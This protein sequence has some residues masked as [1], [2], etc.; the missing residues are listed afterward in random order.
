MKNLH[1]KLSLNLVSLLPIQPEHKEALRKA[2]QF[3]EV[4]THTSI[5]NKY[6]SELFDTWFALAFNQTKSG[7]HMTYLVEYQGQLVGSTRY[8]AIRPEQKEIAIGFTWYTPAVWGTVVNPSC[9]LLLFENAFSHGYE[10]VFFH[11]DIKNVHSQ[12]AIKKLGAVY[13]QTIKEDKLRLDGSLR[14]TV[15]F[16]LSQDNWSQAKQ[17]LLTRIGSFSASPV[18]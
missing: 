6:S 14:D 16:V 17:K 2:A 1:Q 4:W 3:D 9:K 10:K 18:A 5:M 15:E 11:T 8:Y 7:Q 13:T 12:A